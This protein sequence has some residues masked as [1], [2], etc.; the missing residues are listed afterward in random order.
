LVKVSA[1]W[2]AVWYL[3]NAKFYFY[4]PAFSPGNGNINGINAL[5]PTVV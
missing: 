1:E 2:S 4:H 3:R 5:N